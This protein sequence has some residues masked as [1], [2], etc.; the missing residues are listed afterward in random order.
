MLPFDPLAITLVLAQVAMRN[1]PKNL[2]PRQRQ[3]KIDV[4]V[5]RGK[6]DLKEPLA[7]L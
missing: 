7:Q 3:K 6:P 2:K 4:S 1:A 5:Q